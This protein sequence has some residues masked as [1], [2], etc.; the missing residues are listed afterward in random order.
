MSSSSNSARLR[1]RQASQEHTVEM[2]ASMPATLRTA[3]QNHQTFRCISEF[4]AGT[5]ERDE[6]VVAADTRQFAYERI[7][8]LD[9]VG[10]QRTHDAIKCA[11]SQGQLRGAAGYNE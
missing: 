5:G 10:E 7:E 1:I 2:S 8:R 3:E 9:M 4:S 6:A 11:I